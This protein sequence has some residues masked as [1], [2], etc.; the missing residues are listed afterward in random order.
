MKILKKI[1]FIIL[2]IIIFP[3]FL[4][5]LI[6]AYAARIVLIISYIL[7]LDFRQAR[8]IFI[9]TFKPFN[10]NKNYSKYF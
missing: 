3:T 9:F 8:N 2:G 5:G 1:L 4:I 6:T 10:Y 7:M